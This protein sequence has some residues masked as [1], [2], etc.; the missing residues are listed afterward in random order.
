MKYNEEIA[1]L[2]FKIS[3]IAKEEIILKSSYGNITS[4]EEALKRQLKSENNVC[5]FVDE[6]LEEVI[7]IKK[8]NDR[9]DLLL[10]IY[11]NLLKKPISTSTGARHINDN[12]SYP[13]IKETIETLDLGR[14]DF[15]RNKLEYEVYLSY[16][17]D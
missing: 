2:K 11:L 4:I 5:E 10:K 9:H 6:F 3:K 7:V 14:S 17:L 15:Q 8:N 12:E 16:N 13:I 1:D